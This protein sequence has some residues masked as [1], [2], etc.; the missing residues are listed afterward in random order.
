MSAEDIP[1]DRQ[2]SYPC[3]ECGTGSVTECNV[4]GDWCCDSCSFW[5]D[6]E[7]HAEALEDA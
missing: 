4:T 3:T 2:E 1:E 6:P 5:V 7:D